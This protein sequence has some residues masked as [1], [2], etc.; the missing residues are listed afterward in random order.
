MNEVLATV[1]TLLGILA[2]LS[3]L[4]QTM[5]IMHLHES[6][7]VA[8]PTYLILFVTS[9]SWLLYGI[10]L[11]NKPL[12]LSYGVGTATTFSVILAYFMYKKKGLFATKSR[13]RK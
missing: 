4:I 5:K 7:D 12:M 2:S 13:S 11:S 1:A 9:V 3:F 8:L 6:K 10:S